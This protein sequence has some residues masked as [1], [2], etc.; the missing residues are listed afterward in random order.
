MKITTEE[1]EYI[2]HLSRLELSEDEVSLYTE[3]VGRI[4]EYMETLNTLKTE[5]I[6]LTSHAMPVDCVVREDKA[7]FSFTID[8]SL[9]NAPERFGGFFKVPPIIEV[10]E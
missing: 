10:E 2:A 3:Q 6:E 8:E 5:G 7:S 1:I 4:L 9:G